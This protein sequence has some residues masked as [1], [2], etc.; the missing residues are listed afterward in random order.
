MRIFVEMLYINKSEKEVHLINM[1][2][3]T[4]RQDGKFTVLILL[5]QRNSA[6]NPQKQHYQAANLHKKIVDITPK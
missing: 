4:L 5:S 6:I 3:E 2:P 1:S